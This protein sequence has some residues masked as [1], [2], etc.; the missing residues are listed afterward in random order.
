[1]ESGYQTLFSIAFTVALAAAQN[2]PVSVVPAPTGSY[3]VG[4]TSLLWSDGSRADTESP[5]G[6]R[7]VVVWLWYPAAK[8]RER[9][10]EWQPHRWGDLYW[11]RLIR[12]RPASAAIGTEYPIQSILSNSHADA[13]PLTGGGAL[14][15]ILFSPGGG[16]LPL[17]YSSLIE[18]LASH[19]YI[20]AGIVPAYSGMRVYSDGRIVDVPWRTRIGA[21]GEIKELKSVP[22]DMSPEQVGE[23]AAADLTFV[24]NQL[25]K[26]PGT[27]PWKNAIDFRRIAAIGHSLGGGTSLGIA[28]TDSRVQAAVALD[29]GGPV[30][31]IAKPILYLH[32]AGET[33]RR[34]IMADLGTPI[35]LRTARPGYDLW[36]AGAAHSFCTDDFVLPY[37]PRTID[38]A[39]TIE[40]ARALAIT[41]GLVRPFLDRH[42]KGT[43]AGAIGLSSMFP[44]VFVL[45]DSK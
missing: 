30:D 33:P 39:G 28:R 4:R 13:A 23:S 5:D 38:L 36:I 10:A 37:L 14:P 35:W 41:R 15:L 22:R 3:D 27:S 9:P 7:Q 26:L 32:S 20:I 17:N 42:L 31:G 45:E 34:Q 6:H 16:L 44:E 24:L 1:M 43:K 25:E 21:G 19:G 18:D 8:T 11:T 12:L 29:G 2:Q 40:P